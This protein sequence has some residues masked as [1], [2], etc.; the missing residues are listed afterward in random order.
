[1]I[2]LQTGVKSKC[3]L[4]LSFSILYISGRPENDCDL[5]GISDKNIMSHN[6]RYVK[7]KYTFKYN[8]LYYKYFII[9]LLCII[10]NK[11]VNNL[12][13]KKQK[14]INKNVNICTQNHFCIIYLLIIM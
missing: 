8:T 1:M 3:R 7:F 2:F 11:A 10:N 9:K 12:T 13:I 5:R 14:V 6:T 4:W